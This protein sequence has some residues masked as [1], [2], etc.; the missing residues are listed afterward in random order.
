MDSLCGYLGCELEVCIISPDLRTLRL[1]IQ[2]VFITTEE[3]CGWVGGTPC[4]LLT[5]QF[6]EHNHSVFVTG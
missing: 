2:A 6:L 5:S 3:S 1:Q 4:Q